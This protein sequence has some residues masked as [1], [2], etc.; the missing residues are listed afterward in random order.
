LRLDQYL[1]MVQAGILGEDEPVVLLDGLL[2]RKMTKGDPHETAAHL[3]MEALRQIPP[4]GWHLRK[5]SPV[6]LPGGAQ[7]N[8]SVPEPDLS[9]VRG[10][11]RD[12]AAR[13]P[14]PGDVLLVVEVADSSLS[15][16]RAGLARYAAAGIPVAWIVNLPGRCVE[17]GFRPTGPGPDPRYAESRTYG[18]A[19]EVPVVIDGRE[20]G[21]L[22]VKDL[23]P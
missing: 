6:A 3:G 1:R 9:V 5:E 16:D 21:R 20:V 7:G 14:G 2:V 10:A 4:A 12:F 19:D 15:R 17:V 8:D 22:P 11:I 18:E 23:L 13:T